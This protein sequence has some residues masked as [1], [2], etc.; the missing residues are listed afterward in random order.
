MHYNQNIIKI[1]EKL[2]RMNKFIE[3]GISALPF[4]SFS[5]LLVSTKEV[6]A[7]CPCPPAQMSKRCVRSYW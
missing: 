3:D 4:P 1:T 2:V 5:P 7:V 6:R